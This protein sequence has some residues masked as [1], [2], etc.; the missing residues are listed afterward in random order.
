MKLYAIL[1]LCVGLMTFQTTAQTLEGAYKLVSMNGEPVANHKIKLFQEGYFTFGH[2]QAGD[3]AYLGAGG[4]NFALKG[5]AYEETFDFYPQDST[6]VG[7]TRTYGFERQGDRIQLTRMDKGQQRVELWEKLPAREDA[8]KGFWV[9]TGRKD[10][11]GQL[12]RYTPGARRTIKML[13]DGY[14]QWVAFNSETK[15]FMG[16]GGGTYEAESGTYTE[17]IQFF[18]RDNARVGASLSFS[19]ERVGDDWHHSG[20]SSTGNPIYELWSPYRQAYSVASLDEK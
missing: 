3:N 1:F 15:Q 2:A 9:F 18:S 5:N 14:F 7:T 19:F 8:L 6:Q 20:K 11:E 12:S 10:A 16:T 17:N 4:G 13:V